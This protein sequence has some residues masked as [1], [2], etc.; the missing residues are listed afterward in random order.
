MLC[1]GYWYPVGHRR[2]PSHTHKGKKFNQKYK[3]QK[4][5]IMK[6]ENIGVAYD[7][8][9]RLTLGAAWGMGNPGMSVQEVKKKLLSD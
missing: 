7:T 3:K 5:G 9:E 4:N 1:D 8:L 6:Q 2:V